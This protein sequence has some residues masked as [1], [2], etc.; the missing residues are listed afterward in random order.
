VRQY[1]RRYL[2]ALYREI[3]DWHEEG[4]ERSARLLLTCI[5][6][7][8]DY[9]TQFCDHFFIGLYKG[10]A[11][12]Q[13]KIVEGLI[14]QCFF[15]LGRYVHPDVWT[16]ILLTSIRGELTQTFTQNEGL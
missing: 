13:T 15:Y 6:Y 14:D 12:K 5:V 1:T 11:D 8:E 10:R 2:N 3:C 7:T 9:M 4:R 16:P